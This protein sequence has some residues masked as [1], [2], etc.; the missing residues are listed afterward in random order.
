MSE[1]QIRHAVAADLTQVQAIIDQPFPRFFRFFARRSVS[2]PNATVIVSHI[3][4]VVA[5]FAKLI[6]F[7]VGHT[8]FGCILWIAVHPTYRRKGIALNLT[9]T[10]VDHFKTQG[11]QT[12]FASTQRGNKAELAVLD[13]YGFR[14]VG[15]ASLWRV[16]GW[17]VL[18]FY[19]HIW[20]VPREVVFT[21]P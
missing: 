14:P 12:V 19:W 4:N 13:K 15:F 11:V 18:N 21:Y 10:G 2:D 3:D 20:F 17:R 8:P 9:H 7:K 5:G 16:F 6:N 1:F